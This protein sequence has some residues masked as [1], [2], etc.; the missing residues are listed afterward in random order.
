MISKLIGFRFVR[1]CV[2]SSDNSCLVVF[3]GGVSLQ[4]SLYLI[5]RI[6]CGELCYQ[7]LLHSLVT[8]HVPL[9]WEVGGG[10]LLRGIY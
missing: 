10:I 6:E 8:S 9:I 7:S 3:L 1:K 2:S 4:S 5:A